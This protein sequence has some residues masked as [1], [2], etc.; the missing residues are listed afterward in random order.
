[1]AQAESLCARQ[2]AVTTAVT[3]WE[4]L[5]FTHVPQRERTLATDLPR[6]RQACGAA[7]TPGQGAA[8]AA[9]HQRRLAVLPCVTR[10]SP[11]TVPGAQLV[12]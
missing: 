5:A 1:M 10:L 7:Q 9:V 12:T 3:S 11:A 2:A 6:G 8:R 4:A